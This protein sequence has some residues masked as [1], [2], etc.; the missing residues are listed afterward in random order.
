[1]ILLAMI[2]DMSVPLTMN[3][4]GVFVLTAIAAVP[5]LGILCQSLLRLSVIWQ[6]PSEAFTKRVALPALSAIWI[7]VALSYALSTL[8]VMSFDVDVTL[9]VI[10][11]IVAKCIIVHFT[12]LVADNVASLATQLMWLTAVAKAEWRQEASADVAVMIAFVRR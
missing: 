7:I 1:M 8:G 12:A 5:P 6:T 3:W 10:L 2:L 9:W 11:E 4:W